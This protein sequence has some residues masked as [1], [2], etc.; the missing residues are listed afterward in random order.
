V[1][2]IFCVKLC[3]KWQLP[4]LACEPGSGGAPG[5]YLLIANKHVSLRESSPIG[6]GGS[7]FVRLIEQSMKE[8]LQN[9]VP[10][11]A[12]CSANDTANVGVKQRKV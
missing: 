3:T 8:C 6:A 10:S 11:V 5:H 7:A 12:L 1:V 4:D 9:Q 2:A